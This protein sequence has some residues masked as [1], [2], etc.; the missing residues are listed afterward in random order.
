M[1]TVRMSISAAARMTRMEISLR[2][3]TR[4][5]EIRFMPKYYPVPLDE[6][7]GTQAVHCQRAMP[8]VGTSDGTAMARTRP[9]FRTV[10][11]E[12]SQP[13]LRARSDAKGASRWNRPAGVPLPAQ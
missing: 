5:E 13:T 2:L 8:R 6:V 10:E 9:E 3:A 11:R 1:A 7:V 4:M 12:A